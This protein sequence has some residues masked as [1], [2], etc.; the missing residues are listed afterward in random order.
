MVTGKAPFVAEDA[1][2]ILAMHAR[3][4]PVPPRE[5]N[6]DVPPDLEP[7]ILKC[8]EK[9]RVRRFRTAE[10]LARDLGYSA[11]MAYPEA[12]IG[13]SDT[14]EPVSAQKGLQ[15]IRFDNKV[16]PL[17]FGVTSLNRRDTDSQ[18]QEI[19]RRH[20]QVVYRDH[21][22]WLQDLGSYNGT[23]VN[24]MPVFQAVVLQPGDVVAM[25]RTTL[26]VEQVS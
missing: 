26:R 13:T 1:L 10:E 3:D 11:P 8:L 25:G 19:S 14:E 5:I 16:V 7:V 17:T 22:W 20:A 23:Y 2:A 21:A 12:E 15:L 4:D 18:D 24:G 9:D 6:P